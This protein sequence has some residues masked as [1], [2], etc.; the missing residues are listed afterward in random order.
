MANHDG[1]GSPAFEIRAA[2]TDEERGEV[3]RFQYAVF[4]KENDWY[5]AGADHLGRVVP[6]PQGGVIL[7]AWASGAV[8]GTMTIDHYRI[9]EAPPAI[10]AKYGLD[11]FWRVDPGVGVVVISKLAVKEAFR[12]TKY[13]RR[14]QTIAAMLFGVAYKL[15]AERGVQ[16]AF[17]DAAPALTRYYY[18]VGA[19]AYAANQRLPESGIAVPLALALFDLTRL[20]KMNSPLAAVAASLGIAEDL[21]GCKLIEKVAPR[22]HT[23]QDTGMTVPAQAVS[24]VCDA[25]PFAEIPDWW[26]DLLE[27]AVR[28]RVLQP[29]EVLLDR[30]RPNQHLY[31]VRLGILDVLAPDG[32]AVNADATAGEPLGERSW[33]QSCNPANTVRARVYS[34]VYEIDGPTLKELLDADPYVANVFWR[35]LQRVIADRQARVAR[36]IKRPPTI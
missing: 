5:I 16:L 26:I 13:G 19:R 30:E 4:V 3:A 14:Q 17:W 31:V 21:R 36:Y 27:P 9:G 32:G 8:V 12:R 22:V 10:A 23:T 33:D 2:R 34:E 28:S 7:A 20:Q 18:Q 1:S 29:G 24:E 6:L 11:R 15:A 25:L 35:N